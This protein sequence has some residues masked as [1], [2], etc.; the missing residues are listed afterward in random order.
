MEENGGN[1]KSSIC[2]VIDVLLS[3]FYK[4][5]N[6]CTDF[7]NQFFCRILVYSIYLLLLTLTVTV[8]GIATE[9]PAAQ[10]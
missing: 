8:L 9:N 6:G 1:S 7:L 2:V 10:Q 4:E 3:T 5:E